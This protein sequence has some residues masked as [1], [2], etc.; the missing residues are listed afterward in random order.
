MPVNSVW[1]GMGEVKEPIMEMRSSGTPDTRSK[2]TAAIAKITTRG[3]FEDAK[4]VD[5]GKNSECKA[6][7]LVPETN[8]VIAVG[9]K[10]GDLLANVQALLIYTDSSLNLIGIKEFHVRGSEFL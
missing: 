9:W 1:N 5:G 3:D 4:M 7:A 6:I 2:L 8:N 10:S